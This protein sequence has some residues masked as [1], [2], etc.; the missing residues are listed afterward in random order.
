MRGRR[1][2]G[3]AGVKRLEGGNF[4]GTYRQ[5]IAMA[6]ELLE[7]GPIGDQHVATARKYRDPEALFIYSMMFASFGEAE[8]A[9]DL[10]RDGV[11]LGYAPVIAME[12]HRAFAE[13]RQLADFPGVL[14]VAR[15]RMRTARAVYDR[16][17]GA[18]LFGPTV[19]ARIS[20]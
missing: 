9:M 7:S 6:R 15:T 1:E 13:V 4:P 11:N 19:N 3:L 16:G 17:G 2:E 20:E 5:S 14:E 8:R 12:R 10:L 18:E